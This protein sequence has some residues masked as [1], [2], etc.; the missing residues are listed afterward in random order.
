[1]NKRMPRILA[2]WGVLV[3]AWA[4]EPLPA[5]SPLLTSEEIEAINA[6]GMWQA[7]PALI[8]GK[9]LGSLHRSKPRDI[10]TEHIP[11]YN[12]G[13][14]LDYVTL[15]ASFDSRT[16]WPG[17]VHAIQNAGDCDGSWA[18]AAADV[19]S[20][21]ICVQQRT[22]VTLSPQYLIDCQSNADGCDGGTAIEAWTYL[23]LEGAPSSA[24]IPFV[25]DTASCPTRC[26]NGSALS[27]YYA[28]A[29]SSYTSI[30]S[31]QAGISQSGPIEACFQMYSDFLSYKSGIY[32]KSSGSF[33]GV[34]CVKLIGWGSSNGTNYWIGA[35]SFGTSWGM[36]GFF[37]FKMGQTA[38][39]L[40]T[41]GIAANPS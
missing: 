26:G 1:V 25:A 24:C 32:V 5:D 23:N 37:Y 34:T 12:W 36:S 13:E 7:D 30:Q 31:M 17:C 9:T 11:E 3:L 20:D 2:I 18:I 33:V 39:G 4:L 28:G 6:A 35:G 22:Q 41:S 40:E 10:S 16:Q 29:S 27:I 21:R 14:L 38:L 8:E 19:L 15:P